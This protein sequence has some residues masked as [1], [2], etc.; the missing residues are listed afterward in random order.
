LDLN[1]LDFGASMKQTIDLLASIGASSVRFWRGMSASKR[2]S[3]PPKNLILFD[4]EACPDCRFV[5]EAF[6]ELNLNLMIVP[7]PEGGESIKKL[8]EESGTSELPR[9]FDPNTD[10]NILGR[11]SIIRYLYKEYRGSVMPSQLENKLLNNFAS[12]IASTIRMNA[13]KKYT[14]AI[15][16]K[17]PL[18]LYSFEASPYSR[19][20][21]ERLCEL[22]LP[23][24]LINLGK[25]QWSDM[26]PAKFRLSLKPYRPIDNT[27]RETFFR[28]HGNVQVP[29]LIDPNTGEELFESLDIV[30]YL[31]KTYKK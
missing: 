16:A 24:L 3:Q 29:F 23:Y 18:T 20:V 25:Q 22:E 30:V 28:K 13:G 27:K 2:V 19:I 8:K 5:R 9:L 14:P 21:R 12:K 1:S 6:T 4:Q 15:A 10:E 11:E 31:D 26:G 17:F 7:C